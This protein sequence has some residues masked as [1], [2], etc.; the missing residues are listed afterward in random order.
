[1]TILHRNSNLLFIVLGLIA[2]FATIIVFVLFSQAFGRNYSQH[3]AT[4]DVP[5]EVELDQQTFSVRKINL[6]VE[7]LCG[8]VEILR[9]GQANK[10]DCLNRYENR[11]LLSNDRLSSLFGNLS[12]E[13]FENLASKYYLPD[14]E[15][16]LIITIETNY[17]TK[18]VVISSNDP[19]APPIDDDIGDII[20]IIE[21]IEEELEVPPPTPP[22]TPL[23]TPTPSFNPT[24]PPTSG[25]S[26][27]PSPTPPGAT[28]DPVEPFSCNMLEQQGV[29]VSNIRCIE[30]E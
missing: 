17:G 23:P 10:L 26:P 2:I 12:R 29:T 15:A 9:N 16:D 3:L 18:T 5:A 20:D 27:T 28:P 21:D 30:D 13:G 24:P 8:S 25:P 6:R 22:N 11:V 19:A 14:L 4:P 1:M 7:G